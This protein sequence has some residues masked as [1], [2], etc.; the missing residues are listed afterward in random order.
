[1]TNQ[2][3]PTRLA[4][5]KPL[6]LYA[7]MQTAIAQCHSV[8]ECKGVADQATAISAYYKQIKDDIS[9]KKFLE[10]KMRAWRRIGETLNAVDTSDCE[11]IRA[12][13]LKYRAVA[14]L[15]DMTD[16]YTRKRS[17][18]PPCRSTCSRITSG[19]H[20]LLTSSSSLITALAAKSGRRRLKD[21]QH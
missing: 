18:S 15:G 8:D 11:T 4:G 10:I 17:K 9:M 6:Q 16:A 1:M 5:D 13:Y 19:K 7:K 3:V 20:R 12:R 14:G 21:K 2:I